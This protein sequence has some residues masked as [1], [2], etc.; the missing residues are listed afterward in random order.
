VYVPVAFLRQRELGLQV[1][2]D[3]LAE[4]GLLGAATGVGSGGIPVGWRPYRQRGAMTW[5]A[6]F[7]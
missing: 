3:Q 5:I 7:M 2:L 4:D 6:V 1:L